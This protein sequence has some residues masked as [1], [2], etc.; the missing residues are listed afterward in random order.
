MLACVCQPSD[1]GI[2]SRSPIPLSGSSLQN[3]GA[4]PKLDK[5]LYNTTV[6]TRE[7]NTKIKNKYATGQANKACKAETVDVSDSSNSSLSEG[8]STNDTASS[9]NKSSD[10][11]SLKTLQNPVSVKILVAKSNVKNTYT[12]TNIN[13]LVTVNASKLISYNEPMKD[14]EV[15]KNE[16]NLLSDDG[17]QL[18]KSESLCKVCIHTHFVVVN[19]CK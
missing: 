15:V 12:L 13:Y 1:S 3:K 4:I 5:T 7:P 17:K 14:T 8:T 16:E 18:Q 2:F 19:I 11:A 9:N 10:N 6:I